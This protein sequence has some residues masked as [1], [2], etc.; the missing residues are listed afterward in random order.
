MVLLMAE[1]IHGFVYLEQVSLNGT[2]L[3]IIYVF[4]V[5]KACHIDSM[6]VYAVFS[7]SVARLRVS[8]LM[9]LRSAFFHSSISRLASVDGMFGSKCRGVQCHDRCSHIEGKGLHLILKLGWVVRIRS[10]ILSFLVE[11]ST[12]CSKLESSIISRMCLLVL[13]GYWDQMSHWPRG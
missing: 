9:A 2:L 13:C 10:S 8:S 4:V 1:F 5:L 3:V 12:N 7:N 11:K 6:L